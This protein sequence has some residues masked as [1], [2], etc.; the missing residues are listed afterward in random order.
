MVDWRNALAKVERP[1]VHRVLIPLLAQVHAGQQILLVIPLRFPKAPTY[2]KM[3]RRA[4]EAWAQY[5][6]NDSRLH[7][8]TTAYWGQGQTGQPVQAYLYDVVR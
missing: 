6:N 7:Y 1:T 8:V 5:L 2:M 3:I 4:S